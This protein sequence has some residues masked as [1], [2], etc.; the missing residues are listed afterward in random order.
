MRFDAPLSE[1]RYRTILWTTSGHTQIIHALWDRNMVEYEA[2]VCN[3]HEAA[4]RPVVCINDKALITTSEVANISPPMTDAR[5]SAMLTV[6]L[7]A[8]MDV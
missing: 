5:N 7:I 8:F 1:R 4:S 2:T 6:P 3:F